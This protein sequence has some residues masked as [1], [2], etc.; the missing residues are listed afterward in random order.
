[1]SLIII[2]CVDT[3]E[4][5]FKTSSKPSEADKH[6]AA[7]FLYFPVVPTRCCVCCGDVRKYFSISIIYFSAQCETFRFESHFQGDKKKTQR[8]GR[9]KKLLARVSAGLV[10]VIM[11]RDSQIVTDKMEFFSCLGFSR[12]NMRLLE[13][14]ILAEMETA[15]C[16]ELSFTTLLR[17]AGVSISHTPA[18]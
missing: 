9:K 10:L 8:G 2:S 15:A 4:F 5:E 17:N 7:L 13:F 14:L 1:M 11:C 16:T 18:L 12:E 6:A 3:E